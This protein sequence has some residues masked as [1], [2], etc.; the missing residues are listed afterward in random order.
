MNDEEADGLSTPPER[1][2]GRPF[3]EPGHDFN[4]TSTRTRSVRLYATHRI[5]N[6]FRFFAQSSRYKSISFW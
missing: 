4:I 2:V 1:D 6:F 5:D 3:G